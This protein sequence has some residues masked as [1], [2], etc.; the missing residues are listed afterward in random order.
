M[1]AIELARMRLGQGPG[2]LRACAGWAGPSPSWRAGGAGPDPGGHRAERDRPGGRSARRRGAS[3][4]RWTS[5]E[6]RHHH[7][8]HRHDRP[9]RLGGAGA[10]GPSGG[11]GHRRTP[12]A[13]SITH[14]QAAARPPRRSVASAASA[15]AWPSWRRPPPL[16]ELREQ[17]RELAETLEEVLRLN[18]EL[19]GDQPG[20]LALYNQLSARAGGDQPRR[21]GAVRRAGR[22]VQP[23]PAGGRGQA[24]GSGPRS[25]TSCVLR[26]T[27]SSAWSGCWSGPGGDPLTGGAARTRCSSSAPPPRR[28]CR[29]SASCST[30][31]RPSRDACDPAAVDGGPGR[32]GRAAAP[33]DAGHQRDR[34]SRCAPRSPDEVAEMLHRRGDADPRSCA[35]CC[36]TR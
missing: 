3:S 19:P 22:E 1:T 36:R 4:S 21:G 2:R 10:G 24:T 6:L 11:L 31:P 16:D 34:Q 33:D 27:R 15:S 5:G 29:W 7:R 30:W 8:A 13:G 35:T 32:A 20:R 18:A 28:C 9:D 12:S 25:A 14:R 26:S 17:N 23:A